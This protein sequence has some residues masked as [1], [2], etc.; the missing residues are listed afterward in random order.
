MIGYRYSQIPGARNKTKQGL[1]TDTSLII[2][3]NIEKNDISEQQLM[4]C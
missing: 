3:T 2:N 1:N 4:N